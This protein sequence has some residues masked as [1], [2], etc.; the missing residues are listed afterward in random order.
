MLD[1]DGI[2][3]G[4]SREL[5]AVQ[6]LEVG[7]VRGDDGQ[8]VAALHQGQHARFAGQLAVQQAGGQAVH[9]DSRQVQQR[10]AKG[11]GAKTRQLL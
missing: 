7:G 4:F 10:A 6:G 3:R 9:V 2:D 8:L 11:I 1:D 5:D